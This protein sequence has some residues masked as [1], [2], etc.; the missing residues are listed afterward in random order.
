MRFPVFRG[1][2]KIGDWLLV[3]WRLLTYRFR[4]TN[5]HVNQALLSGSGSFVDI[6][7]W[8]SRPD[9]VKGSVPIYLIHEETSERFELMRL[10]KLG[11]VKTRHKKYQLAGI[12]LFRNRNNTIKSGSKVTLIFG[13]LKATHIEVL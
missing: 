12:L 4:K 5:I 9:Q 2:L 7:Y 13:P 10:A 6:R 3:M 8:L 1:F 11:P